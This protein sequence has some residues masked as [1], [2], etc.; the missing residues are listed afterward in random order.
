MSG[1]FAFKSVVR[2]LSFGVL[3]MIGA[4]CLYFS[5]T[6]YRNC[7]IQYLTRVTSPNRR[8][9]VST[10][11]VD[12]AVG[13]GQDTS[14]FS[15][16]LRNSKDKPN[17]DQVDEIAHI[18]YGNDAIGIETIWVDDR[19]L[20]VNIPKDSELNPYLTN[21]SGVSIFYESRK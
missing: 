12:C 16:L 13:F 6:P 17:F 2:V 7:D 5:L 15:I 4:L 20:K 1:K 21:H 18:E 9:E 11:L 14:F 19:N 8:M 3:G 10:Y